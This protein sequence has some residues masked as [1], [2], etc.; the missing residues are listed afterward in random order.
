MA[1]NYLSFNYNNPNFTKAEFNNKLSN[2][3]GFIINEGNDLKFFNP[4]N[5]SHEFMTPQF[6]KQSYFLGT[7][8]ENREFN[9][10]ILL[11]GITLDTYREFLRWLNPEE[12]GVLSF[13]YSP[14]YGYDVKV[15]SIGE[16]T[17]YVTPNCNTS[18]P[19]YDIELEIEFITKNDWAARWIGE[20]PI[21]YIV[22][23]G[24]DVLIDNEENISFIS[25]SGT[26]TLDNNHNLPNYYKISYNL[27]IAVNNPYLPFIL[28]RI[29][30]NDFYKIT[31]PLISSNFNFLGN[32]S[33]ATTTFL[34]IDYDFSTE[35]YYYANTTGVWSID[36]Y[37]LSLSYSNYVLV[38]NGMGVSGAQF[39]DTNNGL[40]QVTYDSIK[41]GWYFSRL[42]YANTAEKLDNSIV[43][44]VNGTT[45]GQKY[46]ISSTEDGPVLNTFY[47]YWEEYIITI[48]ITKTGTIFTRYGIILDENN[49]FISNSLDK[50]IFALSPYQTATLTYTKTINV[51]VNSLTI[52]PTSREI[53]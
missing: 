14:N 37:T 11:R 17:F 26:F 45:N 21:Y 23:T 47:N 20:E 16:A 39:G 25:G 24:T 51:T 33:C 4:S 52:E 19:T 49:N 30:N 40:Y 1:D 32:I 5:F 12:E 18:N 8:R 28:F 9:F 22:G 34:T 7:T 43:Y 29:N 2:F 50:T 10:S 48:P 6:G 13:D 35:Q 38:K 27:T 42:Y 46:F 41:E 15:N 31:F 44:I 3:N 53:I 36:G